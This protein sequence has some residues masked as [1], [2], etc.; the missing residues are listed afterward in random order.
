M[1][2]AC[3]TIFAG[4]DAGKRVERGLDRFGFTYYNPL[5][6]ETWI[7]RGR[8]VQR[9]VQLFPGYIFCKIESKWREITSLAGVIGVLKDS[10]GPLAVNE[11]LIERLKADETE[12]F[13]LPQAPPP[14]FKK[15]EPVLLCD[16]AYVDKIV[17]YDGMCGLE[18][19]AILLNMLGKQ[20]R[21]VV[22]NEALLEMNLANKS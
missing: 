19:S 2:W 11:R 4:L 17:V 1:T 15:G 5:T 22:A 7:T 6:V 14:R 9:R 18:R 20:V 8:Q 12:G 13:L 16:G 21:C 3:V 10:G